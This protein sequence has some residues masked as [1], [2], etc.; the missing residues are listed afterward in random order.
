MNGSVHTE[1]AVRFTRNAVRI[2]GESVVLLCASLFYFRIPR[3]SWRERMDQVK[4]MGYN[5]I[6]VYFPWNFHEKR[7]GEWDFTGDRDAEEFLRLAAEA[8]LWVV[9]RPGPYICSEWD[10]GALPAYLL[11]K[12]G[13]RLRDNDPL[14]LQYVAEWYGRILSIIGRHELN[15]GGCVVCV[16]LDNE[17]DFYGCADPQGYM[18]RLRDL[19]AANGISVPLIACAGQ[20]GLLEA[21]GFAEGVMPTCNF[22][23]NDR[24]PEFERKV[25]HYRNVLADKDFPL[26]VTETNRSHFLLRRLLSGGAKLLGPYLQVSGTDFGFTNATNN[27]GK[28]LAFMTSDYDFGG[29]ISPEGHLREEAYE[30]RLLGRLIRAYGTSLAEAVPESLEAWSLKDNGGKEDGLFGPFALRLG[31]GGGSL[32]FLT[33]GTDAAK[34]AVLQ[35]AN[36]STIPRQGTIKLAAGRSLA[37][38]ANL[39]LSTWNLPGSLAYSTAEL[40]HAEQLAAGTLLAFHTDDAPGEI[41]LD[42]PQTAQIA[43][44]GGVSADRL[45]ERLLITFNGKDPGRCVLT[46]EDERA[47]TIVITD[48]MAA[49]YLEA[50]SP[51]GSMVLAEPKT[52]GVYA[53]TGLTVD[54]TLSI[55]DP[56]VTPTEATAVSSGQARAEHLENLGVYRGFSWYGATV[57]LPEHKRLQGFLVRQAGDVVSLYAGGRYAGTVVPGG[58]STFLPHETRTEEIL[59]LQARVE[60]WGH[61]NFDDLRLPGLRLNALKGLTGITA[62]TDVKEITSNWRVCRAKDD[63]FAIPEENADDGEWPVVGFGGWL[64]SDHPAY[65]IY[66]REFEVSA[67]ADSWTVHFEGLQALAKLSVNGRVPVEIHPFDPYVDLTPYVVPGDTLAFTV[68][69][70]KVLGLPTGRVRVY[71]GFEAGDY[72]VRAGEE[73]ELQAHAKAAKQSGHIQQLPIQ[74][75][76]GA[77][78]WLSGAVAN[79]AANNGWRVKVEGSGLKLTVFFADRVVGR[80]WLPGGAARPVMTGGSP[81]SF[82]L[83]GPWFDDARQE[84]SIL[85]EAVDAESPGRLVS[86]DF[87]PV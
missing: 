59:P 27:W 25:L 5:G 46:T 32:I 3:E 75:E 51:S 10:G 60:I 41:V 49:L 42:F 8:G 9:A 83:P 84:L 13:I 71:E 68:F 22:Y 62:V 29:M 56:A 74:L 36:G 69:L 47:L 35:E 34:E 21:S 87:I 15:G 18:E 58:G 72:T 81:D 63:S 4:S 61:T 57:R 85:L 48:R 23:P 67:E 53:D 28:P 55:S 76:P 52:G 39:A 73:P 11:T 33:N 20:G 78:A 2:N 24:D 17:L 45:G 70:Q 14:F 16:Q 37:L 86:L 65:E 82:Y 43:T 7:E 30:G 64:S 77:T 19:A 66:R 79:S 50:V 1:P 31:S 12:P 26:L 80:L 44:D 6:D 54:W 38:P 40:Y